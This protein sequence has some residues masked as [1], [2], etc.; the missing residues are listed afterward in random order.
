MPCLMIRISMAK[1]SWGLR[2]GGAT[3]SLSRG[4][5]ADSGGAMGVE[6]FAVHFEQGAFPLDRTL[7]A[8]GALAEPPQV[9]RQVFVTGARRRGRWLEPT[10]FGISGQVVGSI[11]AVRTAEGRSGT[12]AVLVGH[13]ECTVKKRSLTWPA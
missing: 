8:T 1:S 3:I 7:P 11:G 9:Q 6:P 13:Q 2:S 5:A 10:P 4:A 12:L